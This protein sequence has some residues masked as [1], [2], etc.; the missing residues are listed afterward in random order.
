M[1]AA[2]VRVTLGVNY[3]PQCVARSHERNES[4]SSYA[5]TATARFS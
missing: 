3:W 5:D 4:R 2:F 1:P